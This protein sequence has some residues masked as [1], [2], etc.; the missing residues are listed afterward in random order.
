MGKVLMPIMTDYGTNEKTP[1]GMSLPLQVPADTDINSDARVTYGRTQMQL[2]AVRKFLGVASDLEVR[3]QYDVLKSALIA[4]GVYDAV[5]DGS[6]SL[7]Q[8]NPPLT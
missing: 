2:V 5:K 4:D 6:Y 3:D 7:M 8:Y 1:T